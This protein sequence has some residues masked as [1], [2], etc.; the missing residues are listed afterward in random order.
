MRI[1]L[2]TAEM[3]FSIVEGL[4]K[5]IKIV[6][7]GIDKSHGLKI[8]DESIVNEGNIEERDEAVFE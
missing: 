2:I 7:K 8:D 1:F 6:P 3:F 5:G 4:G